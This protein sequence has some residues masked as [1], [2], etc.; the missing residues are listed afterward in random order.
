MRAYPGGNPIRDAAHR[1]LLERGRLTLPGGVAW[2]FEVPLPLV[3][4]ARAWDAVIDLP[5]GR[6]AIEAETR[7]GDI[8]AFQRRLAL[9]K[10]DDPSIG[11]VILLVGDTR[12]NRDVLRVHGDA[13]RPEMP[14]DQAALV[15]ALS[16]GWVPRAD[17]ILT[18]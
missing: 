2:R 5:A 11:A 1:A 4:D 17:G 14:L 3:G 9:K 15:A 7:L 13:M 18:I 12:H 16:A 6:V 10:R 8:Q